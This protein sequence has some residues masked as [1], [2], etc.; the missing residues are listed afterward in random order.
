MSS[1]EKVTSVQQSHENQDFHPCKTTHS[2]THLRYQ[3]AVL[4]EGSVTYYTSPLLSQYLAASAIK[5]S[6]FSLST[7]KV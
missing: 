2:R 3:M 7:N 1:K 4:G 5:P 6:Y